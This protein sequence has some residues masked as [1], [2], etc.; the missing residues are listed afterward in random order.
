MDMVRS[1]DLKPGDKLIVEAIDWR[2]VLMKES[3]NTIERLKGSMK[4]VYGSTLEEIDRYIA[5]ERS[6]WE[7]D[8][9]REQFYDLIARDPDAERIVESLRRRP[10]STSPEQDLWRIKD[11]TTKRVGEALNALVKHGG[12]RKIPAPPGV[13]AYEWQYLL[14]HEFVES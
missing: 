4:G 5:G 14:V 8:E 7:R 9:W 1:L 2:I 11:I 3:E 13:G 6:S 12:V 10:N